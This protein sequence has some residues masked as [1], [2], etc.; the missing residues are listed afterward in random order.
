MNQP[1]SPSPQDSLDQAHGL[2]VDAVAAVLQVSQSG[3]D[4]AEVAD[5]RQRYG[6]NRLPLAPPRPAWLRFLSQFH[7]VLLYLLIG[8]GIISLLLDHLVDSGVIFAVVLINGIVG[9][10]QE[11]RAE[12]ALRAIL[13]MTRTRA[14]VLRDGSLQ[15]IDSEE[16]VPGDMVVLNAGDRVP[17]D[18]RLVQVKGL[19][20]NE[21]ALT[22][23]S[24]PVNKQ[25]APLAP[26]TDLAERT[27]MAYMGTLVSGGQARGL[28]CRTGINTQIGSIN[29]LVQ[30]VRW[31][32]TPLQ[33]QLQRFAGQL[34]VA[35]LVLAASVMAFGIYLRGYEFADMF[36]VA[37]GIAVASIPEAIPAVVTVTL[38]IGV[39]RMARRKVL[40]RRLPA[41]EVLGSV[42]VICSDKTGTLTSNIM[43]LRELVTAS[44]TYTVE[45]A[46]S[47]GKE[48][49]QHS[50][51]TGSGGQVYRDGEPGAVSAGEDWQLLAAARVAA[52]C[53]D[54][55]ISGDGPQREL[56][57]DPTE[58]ALLV[59]ALHAGLKAAQ[60]RSEH[61]RLD[62]VPFE[63]EHRFM[64]TLHRDSKGESWLA[65]KGAPERLLDSCTRQLG[66]RGPEP[67]QH[68]YWQEQLER[69]GRNGMR[70]LALA[71]KTAHDG[72]PMAHDQVLD[73]LMLVG[74]A[75]ISDPPRPEAITAVAN[76][77]SAGI[78]VKMIT[79]DKPVTAAAI[80]HE[81]GLDAGAVLTGREL[82]TMDEDQLAGAVESVDVFA[83]TSPANKLQLVEALQ[84]RHHVVAMTGD[85]V[86][87]APALRKANIGVAMG[88][89][90]TDAARE[91]SD[92]VLMDDNFASIA[93][94]V[95]QGRTVFD[96]IHKSI[97]F[98]LP[99]SMAEATVI[100]AAV[101]MGLV[102]P[103]T[104]AQ[105]LWVNMT[106]AITLSLALV[107]EAGEANVMS[108]P[109]RDTRSAILS[110]QMMLRLMLVA[111]SGALIVFLLFRHYLAQGADVEYARAVAVTALVFVESFYLL[112]CRFL[113]HSI[114]SAHMLR[115]PMPVIVAIAAVMLLQLGFCYLPIMQR[116]FE[117]APIAAGDWLLI[118]ASASTILFVVELEKAVTNRLGKG[119][120]G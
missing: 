29:T 109:P 40:V 50:S 9:Y 105:V 57:G 60:L 56:Q 14:R 91:A 94:A 74:L 16:L 119:A 72:Q 7:N 76:C 13:S 35:I 67:L 20:C 70:V 88:E 43:T 24:Q 48:T 37:I 18:L 23:E 52:L 98:I 63:A 115:N 15:E 101:L 69:L 46:G 95:S 104:P 103:I 93:E 47:P 117:V 81:L 68:G 86:N 44:H 30:Q 120:R 45:A 39:M 49:A 54:A 118:A 25:P 22:G 33:N 38:A 1:A 3:L 53:N 99:T 36:Q 77:H 51:D 66:D 71:M 78:R 110:R 108:R 113:Y 10:I 82:D 55:V 5:R 111:A 11:G 4:S 116:L 97:V 28:V 27:N 100:T 26:G 84:K 31:P 34:T 42:D 12:A 64:A 17:A 32:R 80:G 96:N 2:E 85:G 83:R 75:G 59:F 102:L 106:T 92:F 90:G 6:P 89:K 21:S 114:F 79:G 107:F 41:V 19:Q 58:T 61:L 87:D 65:V 73:G 112:N 8:S 62:H